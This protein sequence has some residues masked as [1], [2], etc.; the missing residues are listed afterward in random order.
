MGIWQKKTVPT[1]RRGEHRITPVNSGL[2]LCIRGHGAALASSWPEEYPRN[3]GNLEGANPGPSC[4]RNPL[5]LATFG[6]PAH[7]GMGLDNDPG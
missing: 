4:E 6:P 2:G 3:F 7:S 1:G 5:R